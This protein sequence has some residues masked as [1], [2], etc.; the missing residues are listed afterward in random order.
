M[1]VQVRAVKVKL[2]TG[3]TE[4]LLT[5]LMDK[6]KYP[7]EIFKELYF[8]RWGI[9]THYGVLKNLVVKAKRRCYKK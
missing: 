6:D 5:S 2:S 3:E 7:N 9:E 4:V 8:L 1:T